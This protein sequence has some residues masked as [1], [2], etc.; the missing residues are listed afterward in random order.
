MSEDFVFALGGRL[1]INRASARDLMLLP[2]IGPVTAGRIIEKRRLSGPFSD[3]RGLD[4][5]RGLGPSGIE[6]LAPLAAVR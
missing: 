3:L 6:K 4:C 1:N 2:G 5:V